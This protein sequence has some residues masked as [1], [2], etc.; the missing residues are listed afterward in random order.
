MGDKIDRMKKIALILTGGTIGSQ[1]EGQVIVPG[2]QS[3]YRLVEAY[4]KQYGKAELEVF[5]PMQELSENFSKIQWQQLVDFFEDFPFSDY[6]GV[7]LAHGTDTL[8]YTSALLGMVYPWITCPLMCIASN[9]P[10]G[11]LRSNGVR[12]LRGAILAIEAGI[13]AG[14]YVVYENDKAEMELHLG[15]RLLPADNIVDQYGSAGNQRFGQIFLDS[16][17]LEITDVLLQEAMQKK[18]TRIFEKGSLHFEKEILLVQPYPGM[19]YPCLQL[20]P[21]VAAVLHYTYHA[22]T[23]CTQGTGYQFSA[24]ADAC[25]KQQIPLYLASM[26]REQSQLYES[27]TNLAQSVNGFLYHCSLVAAYMKLVLA[28]NQNVIAPEKIVEEDLGWE[29]VQG[30]LL[31]SLYKGKTL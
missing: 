9:Y 21:A 8:A 29:E 11:H 31:P 3:V 1:V 7:I 12:N 4:E 2:K 26:K 6:Q 17:K 27:Q 30:N 13:S 14:V 15:T 25:Q 18:K 10:V 24:F 22:G 23:V 19:F 16:G 20:P 28:Y 5:S